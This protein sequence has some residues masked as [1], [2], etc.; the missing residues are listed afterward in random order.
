MENISLTSWG[1]YFV[2]DPIDKIDWGWI[3]ELVNVHE[4]THSYF[5]DAIGM[6]YFEHGMDLVTSFITI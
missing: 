5:G 2:V 4:M 3:T 6:R 1:Q